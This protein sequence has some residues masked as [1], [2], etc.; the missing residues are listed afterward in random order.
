MHSQLDHQDLEIH[1]CEVAGD[2]FVHLGLDLQSDRGGAVCSLPHWLVYFRHPHVPLRHLWSPKGKPY[3]NVREMTIRAL[4]LE[5]DPGLGPWLT[6]RR[7]DKRW[8]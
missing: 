4:S 5:P 7:Y 1:H 2:D 3:W 6:K 8:R